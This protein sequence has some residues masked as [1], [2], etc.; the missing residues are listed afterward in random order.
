[1]RED[2]LQ[3]L[4]ELI[5]EKTELKAE[6]IE[7]GLVDDIKQLHA[8]IIAKKSVVK[9]Q[10]NKAIDTVRELKSDIVKIK[11]DAVESLN[12]IEKFKKAAKDLGIDYPSIMK[13]IEK[14]LETAFK[15]TKNTQ[16]NVEKALQLL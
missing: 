13:K 8:N 5:K 14:D 16:G 10:Q 12:K 15:E 9:K 7:L 3:A 1:M 4:S 6:K 2:I 11:Q